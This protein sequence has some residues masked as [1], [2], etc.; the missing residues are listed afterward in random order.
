VLNDCSSAIVYMLAVGSSAKTT[1]GGERVGSRAV[2]AVEQRRER[3]VLEHR[4]VV[5]SQ[6]WRTR[7]KRGPSRDL[8]GSV[9]TPNRTCAT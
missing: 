5:G 9:C 3:D 1:V 2:V 4:K 6:P 8:C 7:R